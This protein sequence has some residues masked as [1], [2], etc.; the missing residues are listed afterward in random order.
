MAALCIPV[1]Q[2]LA[3][4]AW[5]AHPMFYQQKYF[6]PLQCLVAAVVGAT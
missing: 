3:A 6:K 4:T 2:H 5:P 1:I